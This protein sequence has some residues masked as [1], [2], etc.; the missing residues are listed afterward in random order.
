M[1]RGCVDAIKHQLRI[2]PLADA[3][4]PPATNFVNGSGKA[5]NTIHAMDASYFDEVNEV[6]Q[7]EP[8]DAIDPDTSGLLASIGDPHS[9]VEL[10]HFVP[11]SRRCWALREHI[12]SILWREVVEST[13]RRSVSVSLGERRRIRFPSALLHPPPLAPE[14][15]A[16]YGRDVA[17]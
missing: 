1:G 2:Y 3:T 8:A 5:F 4:N 16:S 15:S 11:S 10:H 9:I 12:E 7:E 17:P 6:I 13:A 14:F